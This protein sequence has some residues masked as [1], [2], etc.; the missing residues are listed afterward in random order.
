MCQCE[1][2]KILYKNPWSTKKEIQEISGLSNNS[3]WT[4]ISKLSSRCEIVSR[5]RIFKEKTQRRPSIEYNLPVTD[6]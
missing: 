4:S 1:C 6:E 5:P 2:L 3:V